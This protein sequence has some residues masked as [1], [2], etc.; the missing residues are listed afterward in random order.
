MEGRS[1]VKLEEE[2]VERN[3]WNALTEVGRTEVCCR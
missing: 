1:S 3:G 2:R